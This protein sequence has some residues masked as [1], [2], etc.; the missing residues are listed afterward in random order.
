MIGVKTPKTEK[1]SVV[2]FDKLNNLRKAEA[3]QIPH[4]RGMR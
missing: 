2:F 1:Q 4:F 3:Y